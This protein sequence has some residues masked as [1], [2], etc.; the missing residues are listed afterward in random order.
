MTFPDCFITQ[1]YPVSSALPRQGT[2]WPTQTVALKR[3]LLTCLC[4]GTTWMTFP[5]CFIAQV[6]P[7]SPALPRQGTKWPFQVVALQRYLLT[8]LCLGKVQHDLSRLFHYTGISRK[9]CFAQA[10]YKVT[11]P[12]CCIA[13]IP[14]NISLPEKGAEWPTQVYHLTLL[15]LGKV[16]NDLPRLFHICTGICYNLSLLCLGIV[17][18]ALSRLFPYTSISL[19]LLCVSKVQSDLPRLFHICTGICYNLSLLCLGIVRKALSRLFHWTRISLSLLCI[20]KVNKVTQTHCRNIFKSYF[21]CA[22][23]NMTFSDCFIA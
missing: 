14:F 10:W 11:F 18:K 1:V 19:S 6:Y 16:Q 4:L 12:G 23:Y 21:A 5:D 13:K 3:Y 8:F 22:R 2:K 9:P 15:F 7:A 20:G 17:R